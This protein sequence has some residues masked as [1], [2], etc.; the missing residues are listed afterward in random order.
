MSIDQKPQGKDRQES[1]ESLSIGRT[2]RHQDI[3]ELVAFLPKL[4]GKDMQPPIVRW[5]GTGQYGEDDLVAPSLV[6]LQ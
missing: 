1:A 3:Q 5:N 6:G 4:Y 2:P